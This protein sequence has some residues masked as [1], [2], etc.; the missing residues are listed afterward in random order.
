[1]AA[2]P[3]LLTG[4]AWAQTT[5]SEGPVS[6]LFTIPVPV[7]STNT[8]G[9]MY[10]F[11]ISWV[12]PVTQTYYLGDRSNAAVDSVNASAGTF[13][14]QIKASPAFTGATGNNSTS[15]PNGVTT[16]V[17]SGQDCLF[18][19]DGDSRV[20]SF[21]LPAGT[22][23]GSLSTGG[24]F[25]A[26]EMAF[27][28]KDG[29]L[30]VANNADSP[31]FATLIGVGAK[32]GMVI[33]KKIVFSFATNGA[34]QPVWDPTTD[35]FYQSIPSTSGTT[36]APGPTGAIAVINPTSGAITQ[37]LPVNYCQPAGLAL[38]PNQTFLAGCSVVYDTVGTAWFGADTN[39]ADPL[40]V[41]IDSTGAYIYVPGIGSSDEVAYNSGDNHWYTG[42]QN[43]PYSPHPVASKTGA[44]SITDEGAG[45][46]GVIDGTSQTLD[47]IVPTMDVPAVT[48]KHV[49]GSSHSVAVNSANNWVFVP[50][51]ANNTIPGCLTGCVAVYGRQDVD[52]TGASD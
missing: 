3:A 24:S 9:G 19:G 14:K 27:D 38:G 13:L 52:K 1:M 16:G 5:T 34:E 48:G 11:D 45:M 18:A 29:V 28:S 6:L 50:M 36:A 33:N 43:T 41:I 8:T 23:V 26:D 15:G 40:Q 21:A 32:C 7:A 22:Q 46:L 37:M 17:R 42:S 51:P 2:A 30:I 10:G 4:S 12:D 44:L 31:P 35:L 47:Q 49:S 39:T 20:V 25:R